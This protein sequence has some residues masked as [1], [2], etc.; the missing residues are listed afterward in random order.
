MSQC[1]D[2]RML[3]HKKKMKFI[4]NM[5]LTK[6]TYSFS[7]IRNKNHERGEVT[8]VKELRSKMIGEHPRYF[9]AV[10]LKKT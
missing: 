7:S 10:F 8:V 6:T 2:L 1:G 9:K 5:N 4:F 3:A